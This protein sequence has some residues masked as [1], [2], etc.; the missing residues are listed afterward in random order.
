MLTYESPGLTRG[1]LGK[2]RRK[3]LCAECATPLAT[4]WDKEKKLIFL[5]CRDY[6]TTHHEA[7]GT[8]NRAEDKSY[9]GGLIE[10]AQVEQEH[11]L[12]KARQ[13]A[14]YQGRTMLTQIE[15]LKDNAELARR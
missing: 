11:G 1:D 5:A 3:L 8:P 6:V 10:M 13:L 14:K 12:D 9:R 7:I 4:F 2:L 15:W